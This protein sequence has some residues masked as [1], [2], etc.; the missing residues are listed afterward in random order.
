VTEGSWIPWIGAASKFRLHFR[1][2]PPHSKLQANPSCSTR[3]PQIY[4]WWRAWVEVSWLHCRSLFSPAHFLLLPSP[5][6]PWYFFLGFTDSGPAGEEEKS[7]HAI[8][9]ME[10]E[11]EKKLFHR[12]DREGS[13]GDEWSGRVKEQEEA[14][15][16]ST[17]KVKERLNIYNEENRTGL[18]ARTPWRS[19]FDQNQ[20]S[21][22]KEPPNPEHSAHFT[23]SLP[24]CMQLL[25]QRGIPTVGHTSGYFPDV[26]P[27]Q[28]T[29]R[30]NAQPLT[31]P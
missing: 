1:S 25:L 8:S 13:K 28:K 12:C 7:D 29:L 22:L 26:S 19:A 17:P 15:R 27:F 30:Q 6:R 14:G 10:E 21:K 23:K 5:V 11:E 31:I 18:K 20:F 9:Q 4:R 24:Y 3:A 2:W 16:R